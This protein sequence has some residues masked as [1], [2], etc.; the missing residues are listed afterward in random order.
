MGSLDGVLVCSGLTCGKLFYS[1]GVCD[2]ESGHQCGVCE[3]HE[4]HDY[5]LCKHAAQFAL[6]ASVRNTSQLLDIF[7]SGHLRQHLAE[8]SVGTLESTMQKYL[9]C[10]KRRNWRLLL[11][12][13][14]YGFKPVFLRLA[15][16]WATP[17]NTDQDCLD[18]ILDFVVP[19]DRRRG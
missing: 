8:I 19:S 11:C 18:L 16:E 5:L 14:A 2:T 15:R 12:G 4:E 17:F 10:L 9:V 7:R 1:A 3:V 6:L 13:K